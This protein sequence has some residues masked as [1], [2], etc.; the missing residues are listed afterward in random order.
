MFY[1]FSQI[2]RHRK[3]NVDTINQIEGNKLKATDVE[4]G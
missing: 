1:F 3:D 2:Q 4:H